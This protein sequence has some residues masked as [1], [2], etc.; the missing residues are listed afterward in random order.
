MSFDIYENYLMI[1]AFQKKKALEIKRSSNMS[2]K[3]IFYV[4]D[5]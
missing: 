1:I 4:I 2:I 5:E 3:E